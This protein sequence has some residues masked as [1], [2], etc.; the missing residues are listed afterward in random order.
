MSR[1]QRRGATHAP[2]GDA[3]A[4]SV[5]RDESRIQRDDVTATRNHRDDAMLTSITATTRRTRRPR[6]Y[7]AKTIKSDDPRHTGWV[8]S[9]GCYAPPD[10]VAIVASSR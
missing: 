2:P 5:H 1:C 6:I 7:Q 3:T 8:S 4:T 10:S 9:P